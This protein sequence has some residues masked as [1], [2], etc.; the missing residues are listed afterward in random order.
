MEMERS[1]ICLFGIR[2]YGVSVTG[3]VNHPTKGLCIWL[4]QRSFT[5]QTWPGRLKL[6][7][8]LHL[9]CIIFYSAEITY[10]HPDIP[11]KRQR[12]LTR[13]FHLARSYAA[14]MNPLTQFFY[15]IPHLS[16]APLCLLLAFSLFPSLSKDL[17]P[18]Y[19]NCIYC[20]LIVPTFTMYADQS[21]HKCWDFS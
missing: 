18:I 10:I 8:T 2:N 14:A 19:P 1:A 21:S 4:Q 13:F 12:A 3:Y 7:F 20:S 17:P 6:Y 5:K 15:L 11:Q 9:L 16:T